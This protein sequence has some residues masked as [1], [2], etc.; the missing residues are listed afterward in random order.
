MDDRGWRTLGEAFTLGELHVRPDAL[1]PDDDGR[2]CRR[3]EEYEKQKK[4]GERDE[5]SKGSEFNV[6]GTSRSKVQVEKLLHVYTK[7]FS[8][9]SFLHYLTT[10]LPSLLPPP[11][12]SHRERS[13][14]PCPKS[15]RDQRRS[16]VCHFYQKVSLQ[17]W[18]GRKEQDSAKTYDQGLR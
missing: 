7:H 5:F 16:Y 14:Q 2:C 13:C 6:C 17:I 1:V 18:T 9:P 11:Q 12:T 15:A 8:F 10:S 3:C 4:S